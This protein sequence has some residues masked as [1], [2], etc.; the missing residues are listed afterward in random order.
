MKK[1]HREKF[2]CKWKQF[3]YHLVHAINKLYHVFH[4]G[5][6][7]RTN[8]QYLYHGTTVQLRNKY[9]L[10]L[11]TITSFTT[12]SRIAQ[13]IFIFIYFMNTYFMFIYLL[14]YLEFATDNGTVIIIENVDKALKKGI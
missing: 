3:Y 8:I 9:I 1:H 10:E 5:L 7:Q 12:N 13:R 6:N 14:W 4:K 2:G 11:H